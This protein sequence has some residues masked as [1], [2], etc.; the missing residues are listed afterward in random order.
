MEE[1]ALAA[2]EVPVEED[3]PYR[4]AGFSRLLTWVS[5]L[6]LHGWWVYPGLVLIQIAWSHG[7]LWGAGRIAV[8]SFDPVIAF[9]AVYGPYTLAALAYL[10]GVARKSLR[11]FWPATGWPE[12]KRPE[13]AYALT[14]SPAGYGPG[15][16][17]AGLIL[18][19]AAFL[20]APSA[21]VSDD[22]SGRVV[23]FVAY[24]PTLLFGYT[25]FLIAMMH[26]IRQLRLVSR[27]HREATAIDPFDSAP[28][29]AFSNLTMQTGLAYILVGYFALTVN[30]AWQFGNVVSALTLTGTFGIGIAAFV[31]P[32]WGIHGRLV[33]EKEA[34]GRDVERRL[35]RL[36]AEMY[37]RIDSG[38]FES[39]T[40]IADS[41]EGVRAMRERIGHLPTW[42]W[43]P[44]VL[45]GFVSALFL[46]VVVYVVSRLISSGFGA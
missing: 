17:V 42:P 6:P 11:S 19:V 34:L 44:Q 2:G 1:S 32:L 24:F 30:G 9:G 8:G 16:L 22:G 23:L 12:G 46:P 4:P 13:W 18:T 3:A 20:A 38:A 21:V 36:S 35:N 5:R 28:L 41:F 43:P 45:R 29:Y 37:E 40:A 14:T 27:I 33:H 7:I 10:N 15:V 39:T 31:L 26:T 25:L